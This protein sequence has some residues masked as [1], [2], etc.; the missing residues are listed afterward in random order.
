VVIV[1]IVVGVVMTMTPVG[2]LFGTASNLVIT[3]SNPTIMVGNSIMLSVNATYNC[4]WFIN[5][6]GVSFVGDAKE[7]KSVTVRGD[8]VGGATIEAI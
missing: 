5:G 8:A 1:A 2:E 4:N 3:P 6:T 7:V